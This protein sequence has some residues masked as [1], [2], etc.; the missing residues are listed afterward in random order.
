MEA[1]GELTTLKAL[2]ESRVDKSTGQVLD[3][4]LIR[5][6]TPIG[7][8]TQGAV[9]EAVWYDSCTA[10]TAI[11][12][13]HVLRDAAAERKYNIPVAVKVFPASRSLTREVLNMVATTTP[14]SPSKLERKKSVGGVL[15]DY[16]K[17]HGKAVQTDPC[18]LK[19][20]RFKI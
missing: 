8:G 7:E 11:D 20:P 15:Q 19:A 4:S 2:C 1:C 18:S 17:N 10:T 14:R 9:F 5:L 6:G 12:N 3:P 13:T 16:I